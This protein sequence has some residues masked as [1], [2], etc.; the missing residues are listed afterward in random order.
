LYGEFHEDWLRTLR[1]RRV[2]SADGGV[3]FDV[4]R[5]TTTLGSKRRSTRWIPSTSTYCST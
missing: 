2:L 4:V 1:V 3:L 5:V